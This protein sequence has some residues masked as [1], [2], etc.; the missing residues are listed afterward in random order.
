MKRFIPVLALALTAAACTKEFRENQ[1][2][3]QEQQ[4]LMT[5]LT[6]GS[7]GEIIP[8]AVLV[9]L[10]AATTAKIAEEG[11]EAISGNLFGDMDIKSFS[12]AIPARPKNIEVARKYGLDRWFKVGFD[13]KVKPQNIAAR[14]AESPAVHSVQ[15]IRN[16][17]PISTEQGI[18]C[19]ETP[20]TRAAAGEGTGIPFDDPY[21][22]HQWNLYNDG[23]I[24]EDAVEGADVGVKDAWRLTGGDP[25]VIVAVLDCGLAYKHED[26]KDAMWTNEAELNGADGTDDDGNGYIDDIYGFNFVNCNEIKDDFITDRP[27]AIKGNPINYRTETGHGTHVAG[28]IAATNGNGKGISSIAGG[29][30]K[31]DGVRVMSC[32]TFDYNHNFGTL[33]STTDAQVAAAYIYAADNGACIAQCSYGNSNV[34]TS[35]DIYINGKGDIKGAPLEYAAIRYFLDPDNSNHKSLRGNIAVFAAGNFSKP[36]SMYPGA[37]ADVL[38]VT[39]IAYDFLPAGYTHYGPGCKIAAPGGEMKQISG[40]DE[41]MILSLGA[42]GVAYAS[43][44]VDTGKGGSKSTNYVY[45]HGTSMACPHVSGVLALGISYAGKLGKRFTRE[46]MTSM[47]LTSVNDIDQR[48]TGGTKDY[49]DAFNRAPETVSLNQFRGKMGT[50]AVDAWKFLMAIEGTPSVLVECGIKTEI[51]LSDFCNPYDEYTIT[52]D[53]ATQKSLNFMYGPAIENGK[54][55]IQC[56][57]VGSGKIRLDSAVGKD[58]GKEDGIG[59]MAYSREISI[60]SRGVASSNGGWL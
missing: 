39:A 3:P 26:L 21:A 27:A 43:P 18:P 5:K 47:L 55:V 37:L 2:V 10:D 40:H 33:L 6:G 25:S 31:G 60:V 57:H 15:Y 7:G 54:L 35:D 42:P 45:M 28:I 48:L 23:T 1:T 41:S 36:Y 46:E 30:G 9:K 17:V 24:A 44:G 59:E 53:D 56:M 51:D 50:G 13:E 12:P 58:S 32:Q 16:I 52:Y 14:L 19:R 8:G 34:I 22:K 4:T 49:Y 29:T 38:S 20:V 11:Y